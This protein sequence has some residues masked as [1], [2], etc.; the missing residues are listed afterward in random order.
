MLQTLVSKTISSSY[1]LP[2]CFPKRPQHPFLLRRTS[3]VAPVLTSPSL[4]FF[5]PLPGPERCFRTWVCITLQLFV[6]LLSI[7][8]KLVCMTLLLSS[9]NTVLHHRYSPLF[10]FLILTFLMLNAA[11]CS[12]PFGRVQR[13]R[14]AWWS[15]EVEEAV[16]ERFSFSSQK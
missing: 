7:S 9:I 16:M 11:K 4:L 6:L 10:P 1:L 12:I 13:H 14:Q 3:A 5:L 15:S 8:T 2:S